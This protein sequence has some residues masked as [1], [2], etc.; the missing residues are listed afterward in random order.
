[1]LLNTR[2]VKNLAKNNYERSDDYDPDNFLVD[3]LGMINPY[4]PYVYHDT[5]ITETVN[6]V[7]D[8]C[9]LVTSHNIDISKN[10]LFSASFLVLDIIGLSETKLNDD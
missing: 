7:S 1:M 9:L 5:S 6:H 2:V 3:S 8:Y 4:C 10:L